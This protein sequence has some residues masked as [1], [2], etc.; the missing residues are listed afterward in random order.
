MS[1]NHRQ[2]V[3]ATLNHQEPDRVPVDLGS[4]RNTGILVEAYQA[5]VQYLNPK[6]SPGGQDDF[7]QSKIAR[8]V[9]PSEEFL[10]RLDVDFRG[11]F[12]GSP[13]RPLE[14]MLPDGSHQDELGVIRQRPPGS[15]YY[16]V[17]YSPLNREMTVADL[18]KLTWP[19]PTDPGYTRGLRERALSLRQSTDYALVLHLQD[20]IIHPSQYLRGFE[21]WYMDFLLEPEL[22]KSL[23]DILLEI[24][25]VL[26][27]AALKEVGDLIDVVSSS[28]DIADQ[29]GP[30][31]SPKMY[32]QFIK[33]RHL[34][35]FEALRAHTSAKILYHSC[36]S[37]VSLIPDFIDMGV[38]FINPVQVSAANMD[39]AHLKKEYGDRIGF[40]GAI[41]TMRVLPTCT[42]DEVRSEVRQRIHDLAPGGGYVL[43]AVHNIQPNVPPQNILAMF[44]AAHQYG[45]YPLEEQL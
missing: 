16:D 11:L 42:P 24:R 37:V 12:L 31:I 39:T 2:R 32:R 38:D 34:H 41:D 4:T 19:D 23:L 10:Q 28:D 6:S 13:N 3:Q 30:M 7:G 27:V 29:R 35:Y 20:I 5:L 25:T 43:A 1:M 15:Y 33:P 44:E 36:G 26:A 40:W 17:A 8:V 45:R 22:I 18:Q 14:K 9:N 21:R